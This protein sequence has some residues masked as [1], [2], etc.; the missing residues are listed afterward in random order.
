MNMNEQLGGGLA[1]PT[2]GLGVVRVS[3]GGRTWGTHGPRLASSHRS[4]SGDCYQ[5]ASLEHNDIE[6][7]VENT[8]QRLGSV[9]DI[10]YR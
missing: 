7:R 6:D 5:A 10:S 4:P 8:E 2:L 9:Y 3:D 1:G